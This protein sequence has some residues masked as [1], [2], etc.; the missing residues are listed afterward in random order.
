VILYD[1]L[2]DTYDV[3]AVMCPGLHSVHVGSN[4]T[5]LLNWLIP[6]GDCIQTSYSTELN[7]NSS[8]I[9]IMINL[10]LKQ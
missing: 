10:S 2:R 8:S 9:P 3:H 1:V 5:W 4:R 6:N 7:T